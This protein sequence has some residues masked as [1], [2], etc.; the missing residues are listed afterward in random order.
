MTENGIPK[1]LQ[2]MPKLKF[3]GPGHEVRAA[4][5]RALHHRCSFGM[6]VNH[7]FQP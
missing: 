3:K 5:S 2:E 1:L 7:W 6:L 4:S